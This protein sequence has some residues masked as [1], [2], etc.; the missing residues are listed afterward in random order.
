MTSLFH[1][2]I[3]HTAQKKPFA[4]A[5][6][7]K[8][9]S[10]NYTQLDSHIKNMARAFLSKGL[11]P[12]QRVAIYLP[13]QLESVISFFAITLAGGIFVPIN[14][15]LKAKQV[16]YIL[17][18]CN[19][20]FLMTSCQRYRTLK[21]PFDENVHPDSLHF[22]LLIDD[23]HQTPTCHTHFFDWKNESCPSFK[24]YPKRINCD[25]AAILYTSGST[26]EPKG[27]ILS[28]QNLVEGAKSVASYLKN[29][30]S[31]RILSILPFSFD[32]GLSQLTT[33]FLKGAS[34][35]LLN[36]LFP[37]DIIHSLEQHKITGVS[38]VPA[39]WNTL[40]HLNW[41]TTAKTNLR[42]ITSSG[43]IMPKQVISS[44]R[45]KLPNS[46]LFLMYG[47]TEAFR[48]TY[49]DPNLL[50]QKAG[51]IGK[52]IP[53]A[54]ILIINEQGKPC[55]PFEEGEL[56]HRGVH[57]S[58]G[59]WNKPLKTKARFKPLP[60]SFFSTFDASVLSHERVVWSGDRVKKD[61]DGFIYFVGRN[62]DMIKSSGYRISPS[63][64]ENTLYHYDIINDV[65][66]FGVKNTLFEQK[67]HIA[68]HLKK[69]ANPSTLKMDEKIK[70]EIIIYCKKTLPHFMQPHKIWLIK[71]IFPKNPNGKINRS[72][73]I[74]N[75]MTLLQEE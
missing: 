54:E 68:I 14:P 38:A 58:L 75:I 44:L 10:F 49:L 47:L 21:K 66:A 46:L 53:N 36:Y 29:T 48:S 22:P 56:I 62:D 6:I 19:V 33:A 26:G 24:H 13:K 67:I 8:N 70:N 30:A 32:Y 65:V 17:N 15:L 37:Q 31:D 42:Y 59:Y 41:P 3:I 2:L 16:H 73:L 11:K 23:D 39:L 55:V 63:E 5:L 25:V 7:H 28:H 35:I 9:H 40:S 52:A 34:V 43:G 50:V 12:N 27:V 69:S 20:Q 1:Q 57:V 64:I 4:L 51:S 61:N 45:L 71:D 60:H 18:D 74:Q 72:L